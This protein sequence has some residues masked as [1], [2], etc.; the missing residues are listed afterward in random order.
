MVLGVVDND[1][2]IVNLLYETK[3]SPEAYFNVELW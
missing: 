3:T 2:L 1:S